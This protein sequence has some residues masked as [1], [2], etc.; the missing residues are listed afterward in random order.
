MVNGDLLL[1]VGGEDIR[2]PNTIIT[3]V[4]VDGYPFQHFKFLL[5]NA[6]W[7]SLHHYQFPHQIFIYVVGILTIFELLDDLFLRAYSLERFVDHK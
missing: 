1:A 6:G 4:M 7:A 2:E 3:E 5:Y